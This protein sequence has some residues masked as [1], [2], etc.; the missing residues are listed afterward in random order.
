MKLDELLVDDAQPRDTPLAG[1]FSPTESGGVEA[2]WQA[3]VAVFESAAP[4]PTPGVAVVDRV[5]LEV[6][7]M[8]GATRRSFS[9]EGFRRARILPPS[10]GAGGQ[11]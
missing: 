3:R 8:D 7:W 11:Q 6:W 9:I 2:G 4:N 5:E 1:R 10:P